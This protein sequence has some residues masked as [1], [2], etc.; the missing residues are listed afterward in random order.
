[1][2]TKVLKRFADDTRMSTCTQNVVVNFICMRINK[3]SIHFYV[4][5][6]S[7]FRIRSVQTCVNWVLEDMSFRS[8]PVRHDHI[9]RGKNEG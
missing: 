4:F 8:A 9:Q 2:S 6:N 5:T 1:M 3:N 7:D